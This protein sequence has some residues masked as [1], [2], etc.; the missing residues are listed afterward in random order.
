M[1]LVEPCVFAH[2]TC[3]SGFKYQP[4]CVGFSHAC[5]LSALRVMSNSCPAKIGRESACR[6]CMATESAVKGGVAHV[7]RL[8]VQTEAILHSN[9]AA[10]LSRHASWHGAL[11]PRAEL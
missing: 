2:L 11:I 6:S 7:T 4:L 9:G 8:A 3:G 5:G 1:H 10:M